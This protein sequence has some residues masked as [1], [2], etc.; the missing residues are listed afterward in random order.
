MNNNPETLSPQFT[1]LEPNKGWRDQTK[2]WFK[3]NSS[4]ILA[5]VIIVVLAGGIYAYMQRDISEPSFLENFAA[6]QENE[7]VPLEIQEEP[8]GTGGPIIV[9]PEEEVFS[10]TAQKGDGITH[11]AR[12]ALAKY[13]EKTGGDPELTKEHKIYIE[14]YLQNRTGEDSLEIGDQKT[15][16]KSLIEEAIQKAKTL[17]SEQL[18][19][20]APF[21]QNVS[22]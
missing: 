6:E 12:K 20:I 17:N 10:E 14:D 15:F 19:Q 9:S 4:I 2:N 16:S 7:I 11:L 13:L 18:Q 5:A 8:A 3:N 22:L 1:E 21:A